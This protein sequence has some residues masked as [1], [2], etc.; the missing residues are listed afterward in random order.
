MMIRGRYKLLYRK[1]SVKADLFNIIILIESQS[2][3]T[4]IDPQAC[5]SSNTG[6]YFGTS[7]QAN[8]TASKLI[9][10]IVFN[11]FL[12]NV[13]VFFIVIVTLV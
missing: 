7:L 1:E 5:A 9:I 11:D 8:D 12:L 4:L 2:I 6:I 10:I 3:Y 13:I